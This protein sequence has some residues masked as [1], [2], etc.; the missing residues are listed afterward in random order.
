MTTSVLTPNIE[1]GSLGASIQENILGR[2]D[3]LMASLPKPEQ[4]TNDDRRGI[5]ARYTA[6]LEGNFI[7]WMTAAYI[8]IKS[9]DA[10]H[11]IMENL[12]EEI[13]DSHPVMLRKFAMGAGAFPT[14]KDAMTVNDDLNNVRRFLGKLSA[15]K[16][17]AT[18]AFFESF[19][20]KFMAYLQELA[21]L[22]GSTEFEY[23]EVH[24][25]CDIAHSEGLFIALGEEMVLTP[26][27]PGAD[28]Y[29]GVSLLQTL[30][31]RVIDGQAKLGA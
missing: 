12:Y 6:V 5:I 11:I 17:L 23:T 28:V 30:I 25:V 7:Y 29:E 22:N 3:V 19:I 24:G 18:M 26:L 13:R 20:Q 16:T 1:S 14:E 31:E 27:E 21:Q 9:E 15:V 8:A 4:L 2:I 10:R